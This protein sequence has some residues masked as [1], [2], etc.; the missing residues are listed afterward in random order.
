M[1]RVYQKSKETVKYLESKVFL[2]KIF[3]TKLVRF[4]R[5]NP[6]TSPRSDQGQIDFFKNE[7]S[8]FLFKNLIASVESFPKYYNKIIFH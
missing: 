1:Y 5:S 4:K 2:R 8:Y 7:T 3:Q 6:W